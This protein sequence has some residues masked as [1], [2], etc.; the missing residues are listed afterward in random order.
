MRHEDNP[1]ANAAMRQ[2]IMGF[3]TTQLIHVAA[4][5]GIA[6]LLKDGP[7]DASDLASAASAHPRALYRLLRALASLGIFAETNDGRFEL[8]A[9][10]QT[11]RSDVPG[12]VRGLAMVYGDDWV[13]R[14]YEGMF[15]SITTGLPAFDHVHGAQFFGYLQRHPAAAATF[16]QAMTA[17]SQQ[18]A[19][20]VLAAY[21]FSAAAN[22]VD[23]G[24]GQ[25]ALLAAILKAH[26]RARA[27]LFDQPS[28]I[29]RARTGLATAGIADRCA[30][31]PGD[32][33]E[34]V[35]ERGDLYIM[36][37][38]LHNWDDRRSIAI[39]ENCRNAMQRGS[40]LLII[41]RV[42]PRGN[43]P[44]EAKLFDI[45][46]LVVIGG[47]ERTESEYRELLEAAG[48]ELTRIIPTTAPV[49]I[50]EAAPRRLTGT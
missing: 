25:G 31:T 45:N 22:V 6:D 14:A 39:L 21:D 8:T 42:V 44:S 29:E 26:P 48:F 3:R 50:V 36:K 9:L 2:L 17:Y 34:S 38:V 16:D 7:R 23:V 27:V 43:E 35:P 19:A 5:L 49:S 46:M 4:T 41:E 47:L 10:A 40:R 20:A 12:S 30:M 18:E 28:V 11:L 37:S 24:G 32:F 15:H 1:D 13:W 33:F